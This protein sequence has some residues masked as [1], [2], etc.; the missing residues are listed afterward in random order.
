M[1]KRK[2]RKRGPK[3]ERLKLK[4]PMSEAL[5][6]FLRKKRPTTGWPVRKKTPEPEPALSEEE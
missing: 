4:G 1:T 5:T 6:T 2:P 3:E